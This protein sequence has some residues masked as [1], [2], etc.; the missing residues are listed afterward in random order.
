[1][2]LVLGLLTAMLLSVCVL[3]HTVA[4]VSST[5]DAGIDGWRAV[6]PYYCPSNVYDG[7]YDTTYVGPFTPEWDPPFIQLAD[8]SSYYYYWQAPAK[9]LNAMGNA[10]GTTLSY[11]LKQVA[12]QGTKLSEADIVLAGSG[13]VLVKAI[14]QPPNTYWTHYEIPLVE[15]AGW[16]KGSLAG[17]A[18]TREEFQEVL[19][20]MTALRIRAEFIS[21]DETC[22]LTNVRLATDPAVTS[23][24]DTDT[25]GWIAVDLNAPGQ[26]DPII[27]TP[28]APEL[29]L[30]GHPGGCA[31]QSDPDGYSIWCWEAPAKF[32]GDQ[33][34][35]YGN[36]LT[37]DW[38]QVYQNG[39]SIDDAD[40]VLVGG[41]LTLVADAGPNPGSS[42]Q[43]CSIALTEGAGWRIGTMSG[44]APTQSE[45]LSVLSS[46]TALRIRGEFISGGDTSSLDNVLLESDGAS[47]TSPKSAADGA[48][49]SVSATAV[50]AAF[51]GFFYVEQ[52][53]RASGI[54]VEMSGHTLARGMRADIVGTIQT[55]PS[56]ERYIA[57]LRAWPNG[58]GYVAP[59]FMQAQRIG[60][61][62]FVQDGQLAQCGVSG[63]KGLNN[64]G[65][66]VRTAGKFHYLDSHSFTLDDGSTSIKCVVP[67]GVTIEPNWEWVGVTG[68]SSCQRE[69]DV[70]RR[71]LLI[72]TQ[73]DIT[74]L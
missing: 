33:S 24:F 12:G 23:K 42:W 45:F 44:R 21:G 46:L 69:A 48:T 43:S 38:R 31:I 11:D 50:T 36:A 39:S 41:G 57:A 52:D 67:D 8:P 3:S 63:G 66:L 74:P 40:A 16:R 62:D 73:T 26:Y 14:G 55:L 68:V 18:P 15:T 58:D 10:Y 53:S 71:L 56:G 72:R 9:F 2:K 4:D 30:T 25:D 70:V 27:G 29:V 51:P 37:W 28:Y 59:L 61:E 47:E 13:L 20:L 19:S 22:G 35:A 17:A 49:L 54:R 1:M 64:I 6:G 7:P 32:L 5:F 60:G 65:L 34:S